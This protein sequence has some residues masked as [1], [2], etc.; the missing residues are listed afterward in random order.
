MRRGVKE[1]GRARAAAL[2]AFRAG[3][4]QQAARRFERLAQA[5]EETGADDVV[6]GMARRASDDEV[7]HHHLCVE[8][9]RE[10]GATRMP[11]M[12]DEP[13]AVHLG[14]EC[15][16]ERLLAEVVAMSCVTESLSAALLLQMRAQAV[17]GRVRDVVHEVLR[18]EVDHAR[19]GWAHLAAEASRA[20]VDW[21]APH[22]PSMLAATVHEELF[23]EPSGDDG[24]AQVVAGLGGLT[25]RQRRSVFLGSMEEVVLPGLRRFGVDTGPAAGW[26]RGRMAAA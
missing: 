22:L 1:R 7:R 9:A 13:A 17:E 21:L 23:A 10:L 4:E 19:L 25:R 15:P 5:L 3:V 24:V 6:V 20:R 2:W 12:D 8:L 16:R 11:Q 14:R 26:L 18:D